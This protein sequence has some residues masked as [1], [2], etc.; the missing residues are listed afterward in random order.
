MTFKIFLN[1]DPLTKLKIIRIPYKPK[2]Q[3]NVKKKKND[4]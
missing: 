3:N 1:F 4:Q 2:N